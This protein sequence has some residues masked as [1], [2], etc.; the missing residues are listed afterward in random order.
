MPRYALKR[1]AG[2]LERTAE[3]SSPIDE[4]FKTMK[5]HWRGLKT[6]EIVRAAR[7]AKTA[8]FFVPFQLYRG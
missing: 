2:L 8:I 6:G 3:P 1:Y 4:N 5:N 7:D